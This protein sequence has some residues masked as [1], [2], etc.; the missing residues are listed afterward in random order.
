MV[1]RKIGVV[2]LG[3]GILAA[4]G[5]PED[6]VRYYELNPT[7]TDLAN[8]YFFYLKDSPAKIDIVHGDGRLTLERELATESQQ[9]DLLH[10]DAFRGNA[11]PVHLMT[12]EAFGIY[13]RHLKPDGFLVVTSHPDFLNASSLF[14]GLANELGL[15]VKWFG[16]PDVDEECESKVGFAVFSRDARFFG[17]DK[18]RKHIAQWPDNRID[19][20]LWTDQSSSLMSLMVWR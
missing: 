15:T 14:R 17:D 3:A 1:G 16:T 12:K 5:R 8:R 4:Y 13:L 6:H 18:I 20:V 10:I 11:P 19:A 9:Y 2:G 7:V